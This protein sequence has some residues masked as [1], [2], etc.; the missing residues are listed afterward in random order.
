M[1]LS[2]FKDDLRVPKK[3]AICLFSYVFSGKFRNC[4]SRTDF[5][6][7]VKDAFENTGGHNT[8]VQQWCCCREEHQNGNPHYHVAIKLNMQRRWSSVRKYI[9]EKYNIQVNFS[10]APGNYY[11]AWK[12][13]SKSDA[14]VIT[15]A[16]H[17][18]FSRAPRTTAATSQKRAATKSKPDTPPSRK[19]RKAFDAL[20]L[21]HVV[22]KTILKLRLNFCVL[23]VNRW[24]KAERM[25]PCMS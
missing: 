18:D 11:E 16:N 9:V 12:Y 24:K 14:E 6:T 22:I 8:L 25:L 13:C 10:G 15:S 4:P 3:C 1:K 17:P 19:R 2:A 21:H 7:L 23:Q 5:A 20:D